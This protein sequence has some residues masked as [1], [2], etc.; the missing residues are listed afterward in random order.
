MAKLIGIAVKEESG[1]K[2]SVMETAVCHPSS[3]IEGDYH[4]RG[5]RQVT[6]LFKADW[7]AACAE[8][9]ANLPWTTRRA[10]LYVDGMSLPN[11]K[12]THLHIG[13]AIFE[14]TGETK[15]CHIMEA[16]QE[17]LRAAL[18]PQW[19]GGVTCRIIQG[20]MIKQGDAVKKMA[21]SGN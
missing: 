1:G 3:G 20:G 15:P 5:A 4:S 2:V 8:M 13:D 9:E 18:T 14:V 21:F 7:E 19:R 6:I 16:A 12:G 10:N 17:G 11:Q